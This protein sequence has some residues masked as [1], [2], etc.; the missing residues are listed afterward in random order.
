MCSVSGS[1]LQMTAL[2]STDDYIMLKIMLN[3]VIWAN[4]L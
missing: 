2:L 3:I 1:A 4:T